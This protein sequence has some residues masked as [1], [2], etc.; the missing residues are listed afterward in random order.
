MSMPLEDMSHETFWRQFLRTLVTTTPPAVSLTAAGGSGGSDVR[1]RAEF[2]DESFDPV[3]G[4][5]VRTVVSHED[6]DS[7]VVDMEPSAEEAGVFTASAAPT[8]SGSWYFEAIAERDG[9]PVHT[10]RSS[11]YSETSDQEYFNIRRNT[12]LLR[13]LAE[14]TGG[15]YFEAGETGALAERLRY[16]AAGI[17]ETIRRPLWDAPAFF[18]LLLLLKSAEWLLR[19]RWNTI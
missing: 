3:E 2:R 5:I 17:T 16:S 7:W 11:L 15:E 13:R 4:L 9:E 8:K 10:A 12:A 6:G 18:L 14:A 1:L 19:R